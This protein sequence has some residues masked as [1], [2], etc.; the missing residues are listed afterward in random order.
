[1][2]AME[3]TFKKIVTPFVLVSFLIVV[4]FGFSAMS[5]GPDGR[6]QGG[7]PFS[8]TGVSL[9]PQDTMAV[10]LHHLSSYQSFIS[11]P[12]HSALLALMSALLL[13]IL[14]LLIPPAHLLSL[15]PLVQ[16]RYRNHSPP[17]SAR[18]W[19]ITR[20]LSLLENSPSLR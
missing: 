17:V 18:I 12:L 5:S 8:A 9:C 20:W 1:M 11:V 16:S 14:F 3:F 15:Q 2:K 10:A 13:A 6:M 7:C 4:F 19:N